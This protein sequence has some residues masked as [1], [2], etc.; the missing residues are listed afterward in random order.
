MSREH[1]DKVMW[2]KFNNK[3]KW[4]EQGAEKKDKERR[5]KHHAKNS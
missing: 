5:G 2:Q 4:T 3:D 1:Y